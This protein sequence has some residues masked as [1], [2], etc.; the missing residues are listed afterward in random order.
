M[1]LVNRSPLNNLFPRCA[2]LGAHL[3]RLKFTVNG[4]INKEETSHRKYKTTAKDHETSVG[5]TKGR[6]DSEGRF[7]RDRGS[8]KRG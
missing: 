6:R 3:S 2:L 7:E 5:L 1:G 4:Q 8:K